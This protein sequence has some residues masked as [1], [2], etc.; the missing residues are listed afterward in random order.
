MNKHLK[1]I[2]SVLCV[3]AVL[4]PCFTLA[5]AASPRWADGPLQSWRD[6]GILADD[7]D[8][9]P[10]DPITP[11]EAAGFLAAAWPFAP[12]DSFDLLSNSRLS[13]ETAAVLLSGIFSS[14]LREEEK[15]DFTDFD[16][17]SA[18]GARAASVLAGN[19]VLSGYPDGSLHLDRDITR[20]EVIAMLDRLLAA[21][22][23][24]GA[25][26][27]VQDADYIAA[28]H[29]SEKD[30]GASAGS[31]ES[32]EFAEIGKDADGLRSEALF[33]FPLPAGIPGEAI[34][35]AYVYL[36]YKEGDAPEL[37]AAEVTGSWYTVSSTWKDTAAHISAE[38]TSPASEDAGGGWYRIDVTDLA[39]CWLRG[40]ND[41]NGIAVQ[42]TRDGKQA[43]FYSAFAAE[44]AYCPK[45]VISFT[46]EPD[47]ERFG[48]YAYAPQTEGNCMSYALRDRDMILYDDLFDTQAFQAVY[49]A[50]GTDGALAYVKKEVLNYVNLHK[51]GL[52]IERI[53]ELTGPDAAIDPET[54]YR[55][56][57]RIGFRDR[58]LL[59]G[60][61]VDEDFDYH[62]HAQLADGSWAEK[63]PQEASRRVPGSNPDTDP[64]KYPWHQGYMWGYEK[65]N[66]YY[67]SDV[68]Y[69]AVTKPA[70]AFTNHRG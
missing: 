20:I 64:G 55:I 40:E 8:L 9:R 50:G 56:A 66:G 58:S 30:P 39:K 45:L 23:K 3:L 61:Q 54:E 48:K 52:K 35:D 26:V 59:A 29:I 11:S 2:I 10:D 18:E 32:M 25:S 43:V 68:A 44:A 28:A 4:V 1:K 37:R 70:E 34:R 51:D 24:N 67:T 38:N 42:E 15:R 14:S 16:T 63:T 49:D 69:F 21:A 36:R 22:A 65:W 19:S 57:L 41:N 5:P 13:R 31:A 27:T 53:R 46:P 47:G 17:L 33:R 60:I 12:E 7:G 6:K 62:F